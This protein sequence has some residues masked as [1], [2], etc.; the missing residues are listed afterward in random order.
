MGTRSF[1]STPACAKLFRDD[2]GYV[3][4]EGKDSGKTTLIRSISKNQF[5][6][7]PDSS[8]VRT[9]FVE[10]GI[11]GELSYL[12]CVEYVLVDPKI[13]KYGIKEPDF[14]D[15]LVSVG[16]AAVSRKVTTVIYGV[17]T[18]SGGWRMKLDLARAMVQ[19]D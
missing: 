17:S 19:K 14:R 16:F 5:E 18:L 8:V 4:L 9:V 6:D 11:V 3:L 15:V 12:T 10:A 13:I 1:C 2:S 7:F